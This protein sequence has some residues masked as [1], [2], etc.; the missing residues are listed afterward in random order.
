MA[1]SF[2][3]SKKSHGI[4][5]GAFASIIRNEEDRG[6]VLNARNGFLRKF[7]KEQ[8]EMNQI[9]MD[10]FMEGKGFNAVIANNPETFGKARLSKPT[11]M[12]YIYQQLEA[13]II[14]QIEAGLVAELK[15]DP[16]EQDKSSPII[17]KVHDGIYSSRPISKPVLDSIIA[18]IQY[19]ICK[20]TKR[21][22]TMSEEEIDPWRYAP[23]VLAEYKWKKQKAKY[24]KDAEGYMATR[25]DNDI[26]DF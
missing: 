4:E 9:I 21:F 3:F 20:G 15:A 26:L 14:D 1:K 17:L 10:Y 24:E 25:V 11:V 23:F 2:W 7:V 12:A 5:Y 19:G 22:I 16:L 18:R 13:D 8:K 6:I